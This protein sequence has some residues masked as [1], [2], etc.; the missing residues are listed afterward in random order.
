MY[1]KYYFCDIVVFNQTKRK[2]GVYLF[3]LYAHGRPSEICQ[4]ADGRPARRAGEER[5][6]LK[7]TV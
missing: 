7:N 4:Q 6:F 1:T 5:T 3:F 2:Q